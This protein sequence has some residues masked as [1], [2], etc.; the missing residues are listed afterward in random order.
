MIFGTKV[1][2]VL[3]GLLLPSRV[4][5]RFSSSEFDSL[6]FIMEAVTEVVLIGELNIATHILI[7]DFL[8]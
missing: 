3:D 5:M 7:G 6:F 8:F 4:V 2:N 1:L